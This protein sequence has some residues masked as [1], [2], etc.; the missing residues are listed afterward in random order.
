MTHKNMMQLSHLNLTLDVR[1]QIYQKYFILLHILNNTLFLTQVKNLDI[2]FR[3]HFHV[4][5]HWLKSC[6][7]I[8]LKIIHY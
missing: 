8:S 5:A 6:S 1:H 2:A 4:G 7:A 3:Y